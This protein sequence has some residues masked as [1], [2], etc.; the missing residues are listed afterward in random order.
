[1]DAETQRTRAYLLWRQAGGPEGR[2]D[3]FWFAAAESIAAEAA[4]TAVGAAPAAAPTDTQAAVRRSAGASMRSR[5][6]AASA[7]VAPK[8]KSANSTAATAATILP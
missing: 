3:E 4:V 6:G 1:M 7:A 5:T 8:V 2:S